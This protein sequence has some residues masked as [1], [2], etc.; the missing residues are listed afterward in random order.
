MEPGNLHRQFKTVLQRVEDDEGET[1]MQE[2]KVP[3]VKI[4]NVL[5]PLD[6]W[7][8]REHEDFLDIVMVEESSDDDTALI[9]REPADKREVPAA[10]MPR[11]TPSS[12]QGGDK[13]GK[14]KDKEMLKAVDRS[15]SQYQSPGMRRK[16]D[17][18]SDK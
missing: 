3:Y 11:Q 14:G 7:L 10:R 8:K 12:A 6:T 16:A 1:T 18:G 2:V 5:E 4:N 9:P 15:L 17:A 13:G